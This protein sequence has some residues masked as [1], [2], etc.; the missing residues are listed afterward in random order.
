MVTKLTKQ[1]VRDLDSIGPR[2][3]S[4]IR[5]IP[6]SQKQIGC[7]HHKWKNI[8]GFAICVDCGEDL[9]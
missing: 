2:K 9:E 1:G 3:K 6:D 4:V 8:L 5:E 7:K